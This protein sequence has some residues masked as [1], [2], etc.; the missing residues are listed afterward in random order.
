MSRPSTTLRGTVAR[1]RGSRNP[2]SPPT[3]RLLALAALV[4]W[5]LCPGAAAPNRRGS[6]S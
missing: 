6:G 4:V 2:V 5:M 1:F 3:R